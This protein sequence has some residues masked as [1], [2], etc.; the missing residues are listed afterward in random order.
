M[1]KG[2]KRTRTNSI[3]TE[4]EPVEC[5]NCRILREEKRN[6][7]NEIIRREKDLFSNL[8]KDLNMITF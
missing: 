2:A 7:D 4:P 3:K 8:V 6:A 1:Q 5:V